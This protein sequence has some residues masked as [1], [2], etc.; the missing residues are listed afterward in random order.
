MSQATLLPQQ[1][2]SPEE[3]NRIVADFRRDGY[4]LIPNV[5]SSDEVDAFKA[6]IDRVLDSEDFPTNYY[7]GPNRFVA[8]RLFETNPIFEDLLTR[9]PLITL[10][11]SI[12]GANCHLIAQ[13]AVRNKP[14]VAI[15][16]FHADDLVIAPLPDEIPR[17]DPRVHLPIFLMTV[18]IPLTDISSIEYGPT[19]FV[20]GSHY[21]G[22][23]PNDKTKPSFEGEGPTSILCKA[24]DV[25]LHNG[26][27]W[28][29]GAPNTSDRTR[30]LLQVIYGMRFISQRFYPFMNYVMPQ[31]VIDNAN[32]RRKRVLGFHG[33]GPYG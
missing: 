8:T 11:E 1:P 13:N 9:E 10:A 3:C 21:S 30:Y 28:H 25:Y 4:R 32:D 18:Q 7:P 15:D 12:L 19:E 33:R 5:F 26:Q 2:F 24:G 31:H 17:H 6:G 16:F 20:R 22:R 27:C 29:R 14:G 23:H